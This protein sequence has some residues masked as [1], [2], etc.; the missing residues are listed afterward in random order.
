MAKS[1]TSFKNGNSGKP[2]GVPNKITTLTKQ[3]IESVL[4]NRSNDI[5]AALDTLKNDPAKFIE[6]ISR[7]LP[8][9]L[10]KKT[11]LTS[12]D[13]PIKQNLT[14]LVDDS[15]TARTLKELRDGA[16]TH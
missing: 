12:G 16:K 1:S 8:Y 14:I 9:V 2:P 7:L 10:A 6:A 4:E 5:N 3:M 15:E 13:E 11:D